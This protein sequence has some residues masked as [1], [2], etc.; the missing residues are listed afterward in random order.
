MVQAAPTIER[1]IDI[2]RRNDSFALRA[3]LAH[4]FDPNIV[5]DL[6]D[7]IIYRP[8]ILVDQESILY[9]EAKRLYVFVPAGNPNLTRERRETLF[10]Q[11]LEFIHANDAEVMMAVKDKKL[12]ATRPNLTYDL[13]KAAFPDILPEKPVVEEEEE[14]AETEEIPVPEKKRTKKKA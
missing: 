10:V 6:P 5:Y 12:E 2:L 1:R 8:N 9:N 13:V 3:V 4:N 7:V 11:L 14:V